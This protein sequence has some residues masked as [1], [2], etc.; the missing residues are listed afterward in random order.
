M[1]YQRKTYDEYHIQ[2]DYGLGFETVTVEITVFAAL[3]TLKEY[4]Q[5]EPGIRFRVKKHRERINP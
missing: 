4:V 3:R 5:N 1:A 2:G